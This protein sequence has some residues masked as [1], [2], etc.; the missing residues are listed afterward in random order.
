MELFCISIVS[1]ILGESLLKAY[2]QWRDWA[3]EKV[4]KFN[5]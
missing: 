5:F 1:H 4:Q 3:D 2:Q